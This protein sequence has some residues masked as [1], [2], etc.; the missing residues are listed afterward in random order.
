M[1]D[2][3]GHERRVVEFLDSIAADAT[4]LYLMGD[5][6]DFWFEYRSVIPRGFTRFFG[7][8]ARLADA[9]VEIYWMRGN[10]DMW[11][12]D[13]LPSEIGLTMLDGPVVKEIMGRRFLLDHGDGVGDR[14]TSFRLL[15]AVFRNRL[16]RMLY[17]SVHPRW[18]MAIAHGWSSHSRKVSSAD[19]Y[20]NVIADSDA[21][22]LVRFSRE[23]EADPANPH[24][25]YFIY[26]HRHAVLDE[27][28][29][30]DSRVIILG[31]WINHF[32]YARFDGR[33]LT[34]L[35]Y[36]NQQHDI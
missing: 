14:P 15:R 30:P 33:H 31:D 1:T 2:P 35:E 16:C 25:D 5:M 20:S 29:G 19:A 26:G 13:Y 27:Q 4:Q 18:T 7:A 21:E 32:T 11:I 34:L 8:L 6:L 23:Y 12:F 36:T 22:P 10:H 24:I 28:I 17:A 9:G 3:R